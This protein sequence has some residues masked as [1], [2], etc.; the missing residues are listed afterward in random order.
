MPAYQSTNAVH[1]QVHLITINGK[2]HGEMCAR[3]SENKFPYNSYNNNKAIVISRLIS[4][5]K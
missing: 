4:W 2:V 3:V 5:E 1:V